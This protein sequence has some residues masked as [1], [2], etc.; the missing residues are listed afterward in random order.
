MTTLEK[1]AK[2]IAG[3]SGREWEKRSSTECAEYLL[4]ARAAIE[5]LRNPPQMMLDVAFVYDMY[6]PPDMQNWNA[7]LDAILNE[8]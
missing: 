5:A 4:D 6:D 7:M 1:V 3:R 2:A 8:K